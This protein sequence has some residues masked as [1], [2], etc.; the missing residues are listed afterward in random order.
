MSQIEIKIR[1]KFEARD[2]PDFYSTSGTT[3]MIA[4]RKKTLYID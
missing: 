3:Y 1:V 4:T 2:I